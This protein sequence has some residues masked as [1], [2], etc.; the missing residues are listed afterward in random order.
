MLWQ[1]IIFT[2]GSW[3]F[4]FSLIPTI[5]GK[6]KP[7]LSTSIITTVVLSIFSITYLT[8][9]LKLSAISTTGTAIGWGILA[10]QRYR[11]K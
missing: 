9:G 10:Y 6:Q 4:I 3:I 1:D 8:L 5:Q 11:Q 7:E 2:V